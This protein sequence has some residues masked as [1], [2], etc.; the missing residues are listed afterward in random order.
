MSFIPHI[1]NMTM[2]LHTTGVK[3]ITFRA[4][5]EIKDFDSQEL[6]LKVK[7]INGQ[8]EII[9]CKRVFEIKQVGLK[10]YISKKGLPVVDINTLIH[11]LNFAVISLRRI[12]KSCLS[13]TALSIVKC[14]VLSILSYAIVIW[15][16]NLKYFDNKKLEKLRY[17][18]LVLLTHISVETR[19]IL[20]WANRY[21]YIK[22]GTETEN[23]LCRLTGLLSLEKLYLSSCVSHYAQVVEMVRLGLLQNVVHKKYATL[24]CHRYR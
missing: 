10:Y 15:Y 2:E 20:G 5:G 19:D 1:R 9:T 22:D 3:A 8:D 7:A 4:I 23:K 12:S 6:S 18:Y 21:K 17:L 13:S 11:R 14:Y 16:P 24:Y